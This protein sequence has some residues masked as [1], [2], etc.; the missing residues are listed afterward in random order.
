MFVIREY[1][2]DRPVQKECG[3]TCPSCYEKNTFYTMIPAYCIL[4]KYP[5]N[6]LYNSLTKSITV[7]I[8]YHLEGFT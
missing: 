5:M 4:C 2:K 7:R 1:K 3:F 6:Y 8:K